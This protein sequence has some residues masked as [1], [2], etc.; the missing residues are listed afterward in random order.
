[1]GG[2]KT[3][4]D[5]PREYCSSWES[6][7]ADDLVARELFLFSTGRSLA[8]AHFFLHSYRSASTGSSLAA[9]IAGSQPLITPTKIR[10]NVERNSVVVD[11][12]R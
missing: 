1:M 8:P 9:C 12:V 10:I 7:C 5:S 11:K 4:S 3:S 6:V 2:I